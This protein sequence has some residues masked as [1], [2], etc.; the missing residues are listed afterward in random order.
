MERITNI[1][2]QYKGRAKTA[3]RKFFMRYPRHEE[4][5][6]ACEY[7]AENGGGKISEEILADGTY[8]KDWHYC[9]RLEIEEDY[10]YIALIERA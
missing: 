7:L 4:W 3:I 6:E 8:N 2:M 9:L 1:D 5:R 10:V